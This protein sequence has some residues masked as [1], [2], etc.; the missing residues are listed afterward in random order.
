MASIALQ[1][2]QFALSGVAFGR[3]C[4]MVVTSFEPGEPEERNQDADNP[5]SD[6]VM[7]GID[8]LGG[9]TWTFE[10]ATNRA[11]MAGARASAR[12]FAAAWRKGKASAPGVLVPLRYRLADTDDTFR[13]YGRPG[14]YAGP[15]GDVVMRQGAARIVCEFR[16]S[17]P[18]AYDDAQASLSLSLVTDGGTG[19]VLPVTLPT[20]L[21]VPD[22]LRQGVVNV[23]GDAG[24]PML[25]EITGPV[26]GTASSPSVRGPGWRVEL[27]GLEVAYD[28]TVVI[29]TRARTV[30]KNGVSVAGFLSRKSSLAARLMPG[31][32]ELVFGCT[33][34]T[35]T[36]RATVLWRPAYWSL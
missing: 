8:R 33:D 13:V 21:G 35:N 12:E 27:P 31:S 26:T 19:T 34:S 16:V 24:T 32:Q 3:R 10:L 5:V 6:G 23:A 20:V 22:G 30:T 17:D 11:D 9:A 18:L 29:D 1:P 7:V 15:N 14:R 28:E 25:I 4:P 36:A 2:G